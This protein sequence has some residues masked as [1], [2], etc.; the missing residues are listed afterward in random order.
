MM[1]VVRF[2]YWANYYVLICMLCLYC[3]Y[4][5]YSIMI[6]VNKFNEKM[7]ISVLI[8]LVS[9]A[10]VASPLMAGSTTWNVSAYDYTSLLV[11]ELSF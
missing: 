3:E 7:L 1:E 9:F 4:E 6:K 2:L 10:F 8:G 5:V 11:F